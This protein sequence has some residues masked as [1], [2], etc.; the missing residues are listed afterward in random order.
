ML[1]PEKPKQLPYLAD[2]LT[3]AASEKPGWVPN[4][5]VLT[6]LASSTVVGGGVGF[7]TMMVAGQNWVAG[8]VAGVSCFIVHAVGAARLSRYA[9]KTRP[10]EDRVQLERNAREVIRRMQA[11]MN[12]RRLHR[13][14]S[15][16]AASILEEAACHWSRARASLLSPYWTR[17]DLSPHMQGMRDQSLDTIERTMQ[18]LLVLYT[19]T[20]PTEPGNW[21]LAEVVDEVFGK[22]V[23]SSGPERRINPFHEEAVNLV[24]HLR[25]L[26]DEAEHISR[27]LVSDSAYGSQSRPG[28]SLEAT[29]ADLRSLREAEEELRKDLRH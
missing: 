8:L 12:R 18:E 17:Q 25:E 23:F 22:N 16:D 4:S 26:A 2:Y 15:V 3:H 9:A 20:I 27:Q 29:L 6:D 14:L 5:S 10:L 28:A 7:A 24:Q 13:D 19:T 11:S 1:F 21:N